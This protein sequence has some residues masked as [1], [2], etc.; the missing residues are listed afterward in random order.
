MK[1]SRVSFRKSAKKFHR[2][3]KPSNAHP[4]NNAMGQRGGIRL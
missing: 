2:T 3:A 1:R 4:L